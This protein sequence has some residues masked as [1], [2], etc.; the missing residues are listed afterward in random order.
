MSTFKFVVEKVRRKL[1]S[2]DA[3]MLSMAGRVT[4]ARSVLL[5][6]PNYF[7]QFVKIPISVCK[8]IEKIARGFIWGRSTTSQKP[9]LV[10][11]NDC[12][13]PLSDEGLGL[14]S[15]IDQYDSFLLKLGFFF[16]SNKQA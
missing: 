14:K 15:L 1:D 9:S 7:I 5:S 16:F 8:E 4:L 6:I 10:K 13:Q 12:C 3:Q 11:W 2:W